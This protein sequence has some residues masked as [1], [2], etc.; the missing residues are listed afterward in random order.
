MAAVDPK[1]LL[2]RNKVMVGAYVLAIVPIVLWFVVVDGVKG[3]YQA[4]TNKL[5]SSAS[6]AKSMANAIGSEN[7]EERVYTEADVQ[8]LKDRRALYAAELRKLVELVTDAD[9]ELEK[10]FSTFGDKTPAP[11]DY[12]TE[13]NKQIGLLTEKYREVVTG[14]DGT[15]HVYNDPPT[16]DALR[17]FQKRFWIQ[18]AILEALQQA[19]AAGRATVR[20]AQKVDFPPVA[21]GGG[22]RA[23]ERIP[24]RVTVICPFPSVPLVVRELLARKIPMRVAGL[25]VV[26]EPFSYESTNPLFAHYGETKPRFGIDG[27]EYVFQQ[28]VYTATLANKGVN[29]A[30]EHWIPEPP[31]RVELLVESY[32]INKAAL[33]KPEPVDGEGEGEGEASSD[34]GE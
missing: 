30:Q 9:V 7:P 8:T 34:E 32:D 13:W 2:L 24:A 21:P 23:V 22:A 33:P 4:A 28:H 16:G 6:T 18:E 17:A 11:A 3:Q 15:T 14:P 12:I 10:W 19:S 5:R 25:R 26:K 29:T 20:L 1:E 27:R 31:V